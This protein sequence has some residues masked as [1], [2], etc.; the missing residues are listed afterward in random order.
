MNPMICID[1]GNTYTKVAIRRDADAKSELVSDQ[2]LTNDDDNICV[3]TVASRHRQRGREDWKYGND[4]VQLRGGSKELEVF[5]NWKPHFFESTQTPLSVKQPVPVLA[6]G[7]HASSMS[8]EQWNTVRTTL[9][10]PDS[11]RSAFEKTLSQQSADGEFEQTLESQVEITDMEYKNMAVGY[12]RWLREFVR[13]VCIK[14]ALPPIEE[15]PTRITLPSFG[16]ITKASLLLEEILEEAGWRLDKRAPHLVEPL[17]NAIGIL[18]DGANKTHWPQGVGKAMPHYG[19]MFNKS[20]LVELMRAASLQNG[21]DVSWVM[22]ADLGGYTLDF[23][24]LGIDL[25]DIDAQLDGEVDGMKRLAT[26]SEAMG[27]TDLDRRV[28]KLL[29]AK[30]RAVFHRIQTEPNQRLMEMVH[31][32]L[33]GE[34]L[35]L[36]MGGVTIGEGLEEGSRLRRCIEQFAD[37]VADCAQRFIEIHQYRHIDDLI[38]TGGGMLIPLVRKAVCKRLV[39]SYS[40]AKQHLFA[41]GERIPGVNSLNHKQVRGSTGVGGSS[42]Y[43][44]FAD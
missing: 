28:E 14:R 29:D 44:D 17:A 10:L 31:R 8:D 26:Y 43:F 38:L 36:K 30:K 25:K 39:K 24:M 3:P 42:V 4:V 40:V 23:A 6:G 5:R 27:V 41:T 12:F 7:G 35:G 11:A 21:R 1:F 19:E 13:P 16:S 18:T 20:G 33:Y 32:K 22:I 37:E 34:L 15:I 2:S 9:G